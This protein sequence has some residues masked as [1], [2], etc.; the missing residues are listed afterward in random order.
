[1]TTTVTPTGSR[2]TSKKEVVRGQKERK[3]RREPP[4]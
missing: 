3:W 4:A 2:T 1:L